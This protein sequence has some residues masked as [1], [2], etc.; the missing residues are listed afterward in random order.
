M[1]YED[2]KWSIRTFK[3]EGYYNAHKFVESYLWDGFY[4]KVIPHDED[5][6]DARRGFS[7]MKELAP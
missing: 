1:K 2:R 7:Y 5:D 3:E 6:I 4:G